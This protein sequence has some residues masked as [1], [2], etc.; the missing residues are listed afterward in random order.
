MAS[1]HQHY[2]R[3]VAGRE[4]AGRA[5]RATRCGVDG[6]AR[7]LDRPARFPAVGMERRPML[8]GVALPAGK[9]AGNCV[10]TDLVLDTIDIRDVRSVPVRQADAAKKPRP[11]VLRTAEAFFISRD[12]SGV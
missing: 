10:D 3:G 6:R 1:A 2:S 12:T 5:F 7:L 11:C 4:W 9:S 8:T